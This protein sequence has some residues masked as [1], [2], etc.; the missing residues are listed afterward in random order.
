MNNEKWI[1]CGNDFYQEHFDEVCEALEQ[2]E[3]VRVY[4]DCISHARNNAA[5]E[6]YKEALLDK[7]GPGRLTIGTHEGAYSYSYDYTL[8]P[9]TK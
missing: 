6:E 3:N 2:G 4:I 7:Y 9:L 8:Y 1:N 5:Q